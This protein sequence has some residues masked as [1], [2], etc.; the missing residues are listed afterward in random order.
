MREEF[1]LVKKATLSVCLVFFWWVSPPAIAYS[2]VDSLRPSG[3]IVP[4]DPRS[5]I[6]ESPEPQAAWK[7]AKRQCTPIDVYEI[8]N[9]QTCMEALTKYFLNEPVWAYSQLNYYD[10]VQGL[11]PLPVKQINSRP[12]ILPFSY[13][14]LQVDDIPRWRDIFD[15]EIERRVRTL[16]KVTAN[17]KCRALSER[18]S[19]GIQ[20]QLVK[21]CAARELF[22]YAT[23]LDGCFVAVQRVHILFNDPTR[24]GILS[25]ESLN[26][27][28]AVQEII[29]E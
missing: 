18:T 24:T 13:A 26:T 25:N 9:D 23:Y 27:Y 15:D 8:S 16:L 20:P 3:F 28:Q 14:D 22:K 11:L 2:L 10:R 5:H 12:S 4:P 21:Q 1:D 6:E 17:P 29:K 7:D 19:P